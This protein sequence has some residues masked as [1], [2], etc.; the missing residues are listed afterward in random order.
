[1]PYETQFNATPVKGLLVCAGTVTSENVTQMG[2]GFNLFKTTFKTSRQEWEGALNLRLADFHENNADMP[3]YMC[4]VQQGEL[5]GAV[6]T[7]PL[8]H[9]RGLK[10]Q[11]KMTDEEF[12]SQYKEAI[13]GA[14]KDAQE[15]KITLY[16]QPLG[17]GVYGWQPK[18]A[19]SLFVEVIQEVDPMHELTVCIILFDDRANS[20]DQKFKA[21]FD[22]K[23]PLNDK[24]K[25][26]KIINQLIKNIHQRTGEPNSQKQIDLFN[27][28]ES[29][30]TEGSPDILK[31]IGQIETV[32]RIKR[33][34]WH[35]W[36]T[37]DSVTELN[38]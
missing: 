4:L 8:R 13:R 3:P 18:L 23:L 33:N 25:L 2:A 37:P 9:S 27:I 19:A 11:T 29:L 24:E 21:Y 36:K 17:I 15:R 5:I 10:Q 14:L 20:N 32:C 31:F 30:N 34:V 1:M 6:A 12:K 7:V 16:I 35:F 22:K 28:K 38:E 26:L